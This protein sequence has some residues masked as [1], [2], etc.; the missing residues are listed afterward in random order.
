[1]TQ[2]REFPLILP[3]IDLQRAFAARVAEIDKLKALHRAHLAKLDALFTSL[4]HRAF[5]GE[6]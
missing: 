5:R 6:L 4:Q 1:M 3:P 2:L